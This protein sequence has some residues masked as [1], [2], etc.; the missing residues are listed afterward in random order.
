M[1]GI[2]TGILTNAYPLSADRIKELEH[3]VLEDKQSFAYL[4]QNSKLCFA[5]PYGVNGISGLAWNHAYELT[6]ENNMLIKRAYKKDSLESYYLEDTFTKEHLLD[7]W[8][9]KG[10]RCLTYDNLTILD[11]NGLILAIKETK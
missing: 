6:T 2:K 8:Q 11:S 4:D 5:L 1:P 9:P 7:A 3:R 10:I